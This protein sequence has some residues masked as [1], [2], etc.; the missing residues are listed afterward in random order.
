MVVYADVLMALNGWVDYLLL[1][2]TSR[3]LHCPCRRLRMLAGTVLGAVG[4]LSVLLPS[5]PAF[6]MVF[7]KVAL[8][9]AMVGATFKWQGIWLYIKAA[10][11]FFVLSAVFAGVA[12]GVYF[13]WHPRGFY[14]LNGTVYYEV[15]PLIFV[16][17][18]VLCYAAACLFDRVLRGRNAHGLTYRLLITVDGRTRSLTAFHDTGNHLSDAFSGRPVILIRQDAVAE[19][20][21]P[22]VWEAAKS[23]QVDPFTDKIPPGWRLIP[24]HSVGGGGLLPAFCPDRLS[25]VRP[26]GRHRDAGGSYVALC[27]ALRRPDAEALLGNEIAALFDT[28]FAERRCDHETIRH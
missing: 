11:V 7:I 22:D 6:W 21:P 19:L 1:E 2:A 9:A 18:T 4:S 8:G 14:L 15:S 5:L 26:D 13:L 23:V 24:F 27:D 25:V 10:T 12:M 28:P 17:L 16:A 20:L 3:L